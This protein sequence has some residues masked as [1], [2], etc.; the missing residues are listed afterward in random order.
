MKL[1]VYGLDSF[2]HVLHVYVLR[3]IIREPFAQSALLRISRQLGAKLMPV[4][5]FRFD[6]FA[7]GFML[8]NM[9]ADIYFMLDVILMARI[10]EYN[11]QVKNI[12]RFVFIISDAAHS[13]RGIRHF[14]YRG[15][16]LDRH[17]ILAVYRERA[18]RKIKY[19]ISVLA[20]LGCYA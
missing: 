11:P 20:A 2:N 12:D 10:P 15:F 5:D 17:D 8:H 6:L 9:P 4:R 1:F 13:S 14:C 3:L 7:P 18:F 19:Y 16:L